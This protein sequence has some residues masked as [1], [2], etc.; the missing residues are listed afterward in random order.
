MTVSRDPSPGRSEPAKSKQAESIDR[1]HS[2]TSLK[3][4]GTLSDTENGERPVR[5]QL[6]NTTIDG[7][8]LLEGQAMATNK[9]SQR[10]RVHDDDEDDEDTTSQ[11]E[12]HVRKRSKDLSGSPRATAI[13]E[14]H[15][16]AYTT[17]KNGMDSVNP[18]QSAPNHS[19]TSDMDTAGPSTPPSEQTTEEK[20]SALTSPKNKRPHGDA[21]VPG[22]ETEKTGQ[23]GLAPATKDL[24]TTASTGNAG[25]KPIENE[26]RTKRQKDVAGR[27]N[28]DELI[29]TADQGPQQATAKPAGGFSNSSTAAP[30]G[31][32][33]GSKASEQEQPQTSASAFAASGFSAL[34]KSSSPFASLGSNAAPS[35]FAN[36]GATKSPPPASAFGASLGDSNSKSPFASV[37]TGAPSPFGG[38]KS[39]TSGFGGL[40]SGFGGSLGGSAFGGIGGGKLSSFAGGSGPAIT[41]LSDKPAKPFGAQAGEEEDDEHDEEGE[42]GDDDGEGAKSPG[43]RDED[44]KDGR[45]YEQKRRPRYP[46]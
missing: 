19:Q 12:R 7:A 23:N 27:P 46:F 18:D 20:G 5:E 13:G 21:F 2:S 26:P 40:S 9:P 32:L 3:D 45:F 39:S 22:A 6:K 1:V 28:N 42:T 25:S 8:T 36:A 38:A 31:A 37:S 16:A 17:E 41:G 30:F 11:P 33:A 44:K 29:S 43:Y 10:K 14:D 35:P 4:A 24:S 15:P 34:S